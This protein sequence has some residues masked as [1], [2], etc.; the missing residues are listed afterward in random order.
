M[1]TRENVAVRTLIF[2]LYAELTYQGVLLKLRSKSFEL[3][4]AICHETNL[5]GLT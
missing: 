5:E 1:C 2:F 3:C 4:I